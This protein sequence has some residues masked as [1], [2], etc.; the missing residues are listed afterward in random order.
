[1]R[2]SRRSLAALVGAS[3]LVLG[4]A[5]PAAASVQAGSGAV[6]AQEQGAASTA[7]RLKPGATAADPNTLTR[8]QAES[9]ARALS[10]VQARAV[11]PAGSVT[12]RTVFHVI[13]ATKLTATQKQRRQNQ[14]AAQVQVLNNAYAGTGAAAPSPNSPFRFVRTSTTFTVNAAWSRMQ[15][16]TAAETDA[17]RALHVG[18]TT[19]LNVYLA[20]IGGGLLGWSTFPKASWGTGLFRDGVVLLDE[21]LPG[22]REA[23]Y[24]KGD[25]A[26]HEIGHW[27]GLFHTFQGGCAGAGDSV[28][29]T[30]YEA[31]PAFQCASAGRDSCTSQPGLDPVHNFMD[32]SEDFCMDRFSSGQVARMSNSWQQLRA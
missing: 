13:S 9:Q 28:A 18:G 6:C 25:T 3:A 23:P 5:S 12:V 10:T 8:S 26:T 19:T 4:L 2:L 24:N 1:M 32:Y 21:S 20:N 15:P 7:A 11:L 17:K 30:P 16:G 31:R 27:L 29:D 14:I 22:G